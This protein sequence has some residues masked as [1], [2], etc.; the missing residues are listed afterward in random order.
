MKQTTALS[1][2]TTFEEED[3]LLKRTD[4][5]KNKLL[6]KFADCSPALALYGTLFSLFFFTFYDIKRVYD[7]LNL[8]ALFN[9]YFLGYV[10]WYA[11]KGVKKIEQNM[12]EKNFYEKFQQEEQ[13]IKQELEKAGAQFI[14]FE[15]VEHFVVIPTYHESKELLAETLENISKNSIAKTQ[16]NIIVACELRE[17]ECEQK[18]NFLI[19][20]FKNSF[21]TVMATFHPPNLPGEIPGKGSNENWALMKLQEMVTQQ[22][23]DP[24]KICVTISDADSVFTST[25]FE[26]LTYIFIREPLRHLRIWQAPMINMK[27]FFESPGP[28]KVLSMAVTI[29]EVACSADVD[30][31]LVPF[32]SYSFSLDFLKSIG[33]YWDCDVVTEDWRI[34]LK[35]YFETNGHSMVAPLHQ[36]IFCY[37]AVSNN[38]KDS[39]IERFHQA[40]RH[41]WGVYEA[42]YFLSRMLHGLFYAHKYE[43]PVSFIRSIKVF[44]KMARIHY[45]AGMGCIMMLYPA[46][47]NLII[48]NTPSMMEGEA[49]VIQASYGRINDILQALTLLP[50]ILTL[51]SNYRIMTW[52]HGEE[53]IT[54]PVL[55]WEAVKI[56]L[57][58]LPA[59]FFFSTIP[60]FWA[61]TRLLY[62][63]QFKFIV[64][65]KPSLSTNK[66]KSLEERI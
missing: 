29:H 31:E 30:A 58:S 13:L 45:F 33:G 15:Q 53:K 43:R 62:T 21:K 57:W 6:N 17:K 26:Y 9:L 8:L 4:Y 34:F 37:A 7:I 56:A 59:Q 64:A 48:A 55:L 54:I 39:V 5:K 2:S 14:S 27:N 32:S 47:L 65:P 19:E 20:Q 60:T 16:L 40:K 49:A 42:C 50:V 41:A 28:T 10:A 18:A 61:A 23:L 46:L 51:Y 44:G 1:T 24:S 11:M 38:Y 66:I 35:S 3:S 12:R 52:A 63:N 36:P 22:Q 25:H